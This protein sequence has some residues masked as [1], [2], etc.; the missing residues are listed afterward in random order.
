MVDTSF[1]EDVR[2]PVHISWGSVGGPDWLA[3]IVETGAGEERNT[4][5]SAPLRTYDA[6]YGVRTHD[7]LYDILSLYHVAMGRLRGFRLKDWTD[8]RSTAPLQ[9]PTPTDQA[10]GSGDGATAAFQLTKT[11]DVSGETF[12]RTILKP[13]AGSVR[14]AVDATEKTLTTHFTVDTATGIVTFTGGNIP[15]AGQAVA[16]GFEFD[17]PVRFDCKMDQVAIR[18]PIADVPSIFLKELRRP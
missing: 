4:P 7:E 17:V 2:F 14:V 1:M 16:A 6:K 10:I 18:G 13:V 12:V 3:E 5:W 15:T 8:Y 9:T 11:Y